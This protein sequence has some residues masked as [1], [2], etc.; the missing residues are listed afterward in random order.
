MPSRLFT[1]PKQ[2]GEGKRSLTEGKPSKEDEAPHAKKSRTELIREQKQ[3][4]ARRKELELMHMAARMVLVDNVTLNK[5]SNA[6][7]IEFK[8][9]KRLVQLNTIESVSGDIKL[10]N[11]PKRGRKE[12]VPEVVRQA[13]QAEIKR[14]DMEG[15]SVR[16]VPPARSNA[17]LTIPVYDTS[18][19]PNSVAA[20]ISTK[21]EEH[22]VSTNPN[23]S[24][25][26]LKPI[27][28]TTLA[29]VCKVVAP[30]F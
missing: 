10:L 3:E 22:I 20:L 14:R 1:V 15:D 26:D 7:G 2:N 30:E 17:K 28:H 24:V 13:V 16:H 29:K 6:T 12:R 9:V 21:L 11:V 18:I 4:I 23:A 5:A 8:K 25:Q 27:G 19:V